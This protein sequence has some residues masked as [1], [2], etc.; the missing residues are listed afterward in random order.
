MSISIKSTQGENILRNINLGTSFPKL[1][2]KVDISPLTNLNGLSCISNGITE[3]IARPIQ[4]NLKNL[5]LNDNALT[6]QF[7]LSKY[8]D[9]KEIDVYFNAGL[10][11]KNYG[12]HENIEVILARNT[13]LN[14]VED[15]S[16]KPELKILDFSANTTNQYKNVSGTFPD[17]FPN[18]NLE[19]LRLNNTSLTGEN[20]NFSNNDSLR[21]LWIQGNELSGNLVLPNEKNN[22]SE[23]N[24]SFNKFS[25]GIT[26]LEEYPNLYRV[27]AADNLNISG[28]TPDFNNHPLLEVATF[29]NTGHT[30]F[31]SVSGAP[32]LI[33]LTL[34][35][36]S[37]LSGTFPDLSNN[38]N[39][40]TVLVRNSNISGNITCLSALS[41]VVTFDAY[42]NPN[43]SGP[44]PDLSQCINLETLRVYSNSLSEFESNTVPPTLGRFEAQGTTNSFSQTSVNRIL[45]AFALAGKNSGTRVLNIGGGTSLLISTPD[46][47]TN[48]YMISAARSGVTG[49]P[50]GT[51]TRPA[52][53]FT[54]TANITGHNLLQNDIITINN[55][56]NFSYTTKVNSVIS[57]DQFTFTAPTSSSSTVSNSNS[58][59][60][61]LRKSLTDD[62]VLYRYQQLA[63]PNNLE[64]LGWTVSIRFP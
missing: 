21:I 53:S 1:G 36:T 34:P 14:G 29:N 41:S 30:S 25:S 60:G 49:F 56:T 33:Q 3:I 35:N 59:T 39:L 15:I 9:L 28:R 42:T 58:T 50:A 31:G 46:F 7:D 44:I 12:N 5:N 16:N 11:L 40:V 22:L 24:I 48:V 4:H 37:A 63:L 32:N 26:S 47:T 43:L 38:K 6:G 52:N 13:V 10:E 54:V 23:V 19:V 27:F 17:F 64:G 8:P 45:S 62:S 61:R 55:V 51:F 2:G 57:P 18:T 20:P